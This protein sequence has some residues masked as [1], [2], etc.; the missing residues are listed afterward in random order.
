MNLGFTA[1]E[2]ESAKDQKTRVEEKFTVGAER[3]DVY[4]PLLQDKRIAIVGNHSSRVGERHLVDTLLSLGLDVKRLFSPEHG[5]RG[6]EDAGAKV[7]DGRDP[8]SGLPVV[9]LYGDHKKPRKSE[10]QEIDLI[11]FD[12]QDVGVRFYT[13]LSTLHYV[14]QAAAEEGIEVLVLDRPNPNL[15]KID[16]P[17]M[18]EESMSFVGLHP[19]PIVYGLSIG[20]YAQMI[21][22]EQWLGQGLN[23]KLK[24][25]A[26]QGLHRASTYEFPLPPSPNLPNMKAIKL[27]PSLALFEGTVISVGRGT[28][29]PF[30][31]IGHP[32]LKEHYDHSFVPKSFKGASDPKLKGENCYG[33]LLTDSE[34]SESGFNLSYLLELYGNFPEKGNFFNSYFHLLAGSKA[35]EKQIASGLT[36]KEIRRSWQA[37]LNAFEE[38]RNKYLIYPAVPN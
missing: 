11:L 28:E 22:G 2:T 26:C 35:L 9:S 15:N 5:F 1:C 18:E 8:K 19:V 34:Q 30:Q 7:E 31:Q 29:L 17:T 4:L 12:L 16:G 33:L 21:K 23:P 36:E 10:L 6:T 32:K 14:M 20:E 27:Y 24:V 38:I 25:I 13:Y 3:L 37:D